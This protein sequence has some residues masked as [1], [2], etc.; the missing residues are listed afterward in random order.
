[1][2]LK[3]VLRP[4]SRYVVVRTSF[5]GLREDLKCPV[6]C[7]LSPSC[8]VEVSLSNQL[9]E[10]FSSVPCPHPGNEVSLLL[11]KTVYCGVTRT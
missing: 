2:L 11:W 9:L 3:C 6:R 4:C 8:I 10:N 1:M 7:L 5:Q